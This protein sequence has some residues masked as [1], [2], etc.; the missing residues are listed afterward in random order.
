MDNGKKMK[1]FIYT[2]AFLGMFY[3]SISQAAAASGA[4][5]SDE[6]ALEEVSAGNQTKLVATVTEKAALRLAMLQ[7]SEGEEAEGGSSKKAFSG[8]GAADPTAEDKEYKKY[9]ETVTAAVTGANAF[10]DQA[11]NPLA[12]LLGNASAT[13]G[14][15][16]NLFRDNPYAVRFLTSEDGLP[17]IPTKAMQLLFM[18]E[19]GMRIFRSENGEEVLRIFGLRLVEATEAVEDPDLAAAIAASLEH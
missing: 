17:L 12:Q 11:E 14:D 8:A 1:K 6:A 3:A 19:N 16:R 4:G 7:S 13:G 18:S 5:A 10:L 9:A 2:I 15:A